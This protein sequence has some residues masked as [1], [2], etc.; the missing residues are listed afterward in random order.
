MLE[1]AGEI[2]LRVAAQHI[3]D[4]LVHSR[5]VRM[6]RSFVKTKGRQSH[7]C[8]RFALSIYSISMIVCVCNAIREAEVRQ[9]ARDGAACPVSAYR[10]F[11]RKP[12]CG[13]CVSFARQIIAAE[14]A[15]A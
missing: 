2:D 3:E 8:E 4:V 15:T 14:R 9:A 7:Y 10:V 13:Q 5:I 1:M 11:G 6:A 12:R